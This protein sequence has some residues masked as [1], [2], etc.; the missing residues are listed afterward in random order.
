MIEAG[1]SEGLCCELCYQ[2]GLEGCDLDPWYKKIVELD[3]RRR[4][5]DTLYL[6]YV[7]FHVL[8]VK[9]LSDD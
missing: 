5:Q 2:F 3:F 1:G 7:N 8:V 6:L 4:L 9:W